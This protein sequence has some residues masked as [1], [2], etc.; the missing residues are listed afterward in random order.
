MSSLEGLL[1]ADDSARSIGVARSMSAMT[2]IAI[3]FCCAAKSR[4]VPTIGIGGNLTAPPLPH[5][6]T[7]G[8]VYGGSRSYANALRSNDSTRVGWAFGFMHHRERFDVFPSRLPG[9]TRR[10]RWEVQS[11]LDVQ[12]LVALEIH[13]LLASPLVQA[14]SHRFRF[15]LSVDSTFR[16]RSASLDERFH[17]NDPMGFDP[18]FVIPGCVPAGDSRSERRPGIHSPCGGYGFRARLSRASRVTR[19]PE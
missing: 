6:R 17:E 14:F 3:K 10:R 18:T 1:I 8:S 7:Y 2:P 16:R 11:Q 4:E 19:A 9:F 5:H 15:G 12:P 13:V